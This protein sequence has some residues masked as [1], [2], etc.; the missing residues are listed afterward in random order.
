MFIDRSEHGRAGDYD[1]LSNEE[2]E[3]KLKLLDELDRLDAEQAGDKEAQDKST[4]G[5]DAP[6]LVP[7]ELQAL[8]RR[9]GSVPRRAA[10]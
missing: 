1:H 6:A 7:G 5:A 9:S 10:G 8:L 2:V 3:E 4:A